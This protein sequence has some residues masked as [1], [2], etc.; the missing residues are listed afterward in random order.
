M[1]SVREF[2]TKQ[3][4]LDVWLIVFQLYSK[5]HVKTVSQCIFTH[6]LC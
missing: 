3:A 2:R 5:T 1:Y 4:K 6:K